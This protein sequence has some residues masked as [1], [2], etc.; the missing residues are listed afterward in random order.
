LQQY[1]RE[2]ARFFPRELRNSDIP[3]VA[4]LLAWQIGFELVSDVEF[5]SPDAKSFSSIRLLGDK[6]TPP[7]LICIELMCKWENART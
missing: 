6:Q 4:A 3:Q 7:S 5:R 2:R 1:R